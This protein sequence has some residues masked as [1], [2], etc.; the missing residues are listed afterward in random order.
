MKKEKEY[1]FYEEIK[2]WSFD[3]FEIETEKYTLW[4]LYEE[5]RKVANKP[6]RMLDVLIRELAIS[7]RVPWLLLLRFIALS[8]STILAYYM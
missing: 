3:K 7:R 1:D 6:R 8:L 4:D 5:L 2:D